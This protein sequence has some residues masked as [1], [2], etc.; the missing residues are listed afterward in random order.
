MRNNK[1]NIKSTQ[2]QTLQSIAKHYMAFD[3]GKHY[4]RL[5]SLVLEFQIYSS[6]RQLFLSLVCNKSKKNESR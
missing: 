6:I 5:V 2:N 1:Q 3:K 4:M